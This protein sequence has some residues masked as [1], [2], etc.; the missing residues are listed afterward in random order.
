MDFKGG[1]FAQ[2]QETK[3]KQTTL[4]WGEGGQYFQKRRF[5]SST[6]VRDCGHLHASP[7]RSMVCSY[8]LTFLEGTAVFT[9]G[10]KLTASSE[11]YLF[12]TDWIKSPNSLKGVPVPHIPRRFMY[13]IFFGS[14]APANNIELC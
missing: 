12:S 7:N 1:S 10:S 9:K 14:D 5:S 2:I 13:A 4:K 6:F 3:P 8:C 11:T